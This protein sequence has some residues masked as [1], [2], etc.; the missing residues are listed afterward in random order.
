[1]V[2]SFWV[3]EL[4]G[5]TDV[6]PGHTNHT[7]MQATAPG[8]YHGQCAEFCGMEHALMRLEVVA[9]PQAEFQQWAEGQ[10][11]AP[12][13]PSGDAATR[14][15]QTFM[16]SP[17]IGCHTI[18]GTAAQGKIGPNLS[19]LGS[20]RLFAGG[21]YETTPENLARWI[22]NPQD[23]KPGALMPDTGLSPEQIGDVVAYLLSLK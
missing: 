17:C 18:E 16:S 3:P 11:A 14:G 8:T 20:R 5:K 1:V 4:G 10:R 19:H 23:L 7:T 2:H 22:D 13:A 12:A 21:S 15:Q 9:S 6:V